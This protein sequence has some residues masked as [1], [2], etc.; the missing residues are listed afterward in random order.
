MAK[1]KTQ[2]PHKPRPEEVFGL[3]PKERLFDKVSHE[4]LVEFL[5]DD[6]TTIHRMEESRNNY[7]EFLFVTLSR[8]G[9][10]R[11]ILVTFWGAG[12]HDYRERWLIEEWHW[13]LAHP[14]PEMLEQQ[15]EREEAQQ[16]L[17]ERL[18]SIRPYVGEET[19]SGRG[20]LFEMLADLTDEDGALSEIEDLGD[21]ADWLGDGLE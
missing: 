14:F 19:Q 13:Y 7:G 2:P 11:R 8:P 17:T 4:R 12:Y 1:E 20:K 9:Q 16:R 18:E 6:A 15:V 10:E 3:T 5:A 21:M